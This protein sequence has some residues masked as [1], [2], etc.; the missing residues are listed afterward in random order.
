MSMQICKMRSAVQLCDALVP[1]HGQATQNWP[2]LGDAGRPLSQHYAEAGLGSPASQDVE[3]HLIPHLQME[4][5]RGRCVGCYQ[6]TSSQTSSM[7][8]LPF[9]AGSSSPAAVQ[10][11]L[12]LVTL[13]SA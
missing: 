6:A 2:S 3:P 10:V 5:G 7:L 8:Q 11:S 1:N 12:P 9:N 4:G 13:R